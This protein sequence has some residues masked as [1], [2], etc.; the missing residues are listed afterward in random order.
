M[1]TKRLK[2]MLYILP[3]GLLIWLGGRYVPEGMDEWYMFAWLIPVI[4][5]SLWWSRRTSGRNGAVLSAYA[6][7]RDWEFKPNRMKRR[8]KPVCRV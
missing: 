2:S 4:I 6:A 5:V 3:L 7:Q 1:D 8:I